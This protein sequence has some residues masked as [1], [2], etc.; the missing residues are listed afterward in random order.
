MVGIF[1]KPSVS[2]VPFVKVQLEIQQ[3]SLKAFG[4]SSA[5]AGAVSNQTGKLCTAANKNG[6]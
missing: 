4:M 3:S 2:Y 5:C 6:Q 1:C